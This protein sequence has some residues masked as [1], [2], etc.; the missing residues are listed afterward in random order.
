MKGL[1]DFFEAFVRD[2]GIDL[3]GGDRSM[4]EH[5][6]DRTDVGTISEEIGCK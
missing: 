6:L 2:V 1:V 3:S 4:T 5:G